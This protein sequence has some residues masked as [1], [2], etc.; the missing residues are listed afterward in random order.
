M[1]TTAMTIPILNNEMKEKKTTFRMCVVC[2]RM[3]ER[4]ELNR[5]VRLPDGGV[6]FDEI[7]NADGRGAY[8]CRDAKCIEKCR[9][10]KLLNKHLKTTV[11]EEIYIKLKVKE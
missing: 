9:K 3:I 2:R 7:G 4:T 11:P 6:L 10:S 8:I 5:V 1:T